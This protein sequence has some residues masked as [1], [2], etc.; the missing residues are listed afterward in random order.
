VTRWPLTIRTRLTLWYTAVLVAIL[1]VVSALAYSLLRWS[2]LH[3]VDQALVTTA[4]VVHEASE[5]VA[6]ATTVIPGPEA[7]LR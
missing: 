2:V 5:E 1:L 7:A 6:A 3:Y 4:Q